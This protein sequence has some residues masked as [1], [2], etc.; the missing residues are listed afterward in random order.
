MATVPERVVIAG[1][2]FRIEVVDDL[3]QIH[4]DE[5][6]VGITNAQLGIIKVAAWPRYQ[7]P[8]S[9]RDTLLHEIMHSV[10]GLSHGNLSSK[11]EER[12]IRSLSTGL[13]DTLRRNPDLAQF[14]LEEE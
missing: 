9:A 5:T 4:P 14:L 3:T 13:L 10:Y 2:R 6:I 12:A 8:D 1:Q 11:E 7:S